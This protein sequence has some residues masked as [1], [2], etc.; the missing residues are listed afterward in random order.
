MDVWAIGCIFYY[1]LFGKLPFVGRTSAE[2]IKLIVEGAYKLPKD[3]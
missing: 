2:T 3:V 1:L